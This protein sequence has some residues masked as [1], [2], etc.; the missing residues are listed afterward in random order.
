MLGVSD[1]QRLS[2]GKLI[3]LGQLAQAAAAELAKA[4]VKPMV[5]LPE[6]SAI[7]GDRSKIGR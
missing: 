5:M 7:D 2:M 1:A 6:D 3:Q 4:E